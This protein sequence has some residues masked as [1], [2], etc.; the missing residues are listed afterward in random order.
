MWRETYLLPGQTHTISLSAPEDNAVIEG[1]DFAA[2]FTVL[3]ENCTPQVLGGSTNPPT[4]DDP[5]DQ[6]N[7]EGDS[8]VLDITA[9][10]PDGDSLTFGVD[11]LPAGLAIN[12]ASGQIAGT[13]AVGS[14]GLYNV[15]VTAD[16]GNGGTGSAS[17]TWTV[18]E[19]PLP[20]VPSVVGQA[21]D[22]AE[23]AIVL[24]GLT[25]G[26]VTTAND[27]SA[28]VGS[29]ISQDPGAGASVA[30]G[31]AVNLV[32]SA[33]IINGDFEAGRNVGW[34]ERSSRGYRLVTTGS[35]HSG[36]WR[37]W[38]AGANREKSRIHQQI[39]IPSEGATLT[40][41][42]RIRSYDWCGYDFGYVRI[43]STT[44]KRYYLCS[45]NNMSGYV[46]DSIDLSAY[47]GQDITLSFMATND[48]VYASS[49]YIDDVQLIAGS[50]QAANAEVAAQYAELE[51]RPEAAPDGESDERITDDVQMSQQNKIYLPLMT[52]E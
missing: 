12:A 43:G 20:T 36:S 27:S 45:R 49:L 25:V 6:N 14:A 28:P 19:P 44:I 39:T 30:S 37:A 17:F 15:T 42:Y 48:Y 33:G 38:L 50:I 32:V 24:A 3:L 7:Q 40:F 2:G 31:T 22:E 41:W 34:S 21:L 51:A 26:T 47:A 9:N 13:L 29:V 52:T 5:G 46:Q 4:V 11:G 35:A 10:D 18:S 23:N 16:D 8:I 1:L